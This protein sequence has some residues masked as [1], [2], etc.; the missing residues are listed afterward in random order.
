ME[1]IEL[2]IA[3]GLV[4]KEPTKLVCHGLGSCVAIMVY[5]PK[6]R[7]GGLAHALL[8]DESFSTKKDNS[9][10]F[11]DSATTWLIEE[12]VK[13][14]SNK[15]RLNAKIVGGA[16]LFKELKEAIGN[17]NAKRAEET[18]SR[19]GVKLVV[20]DVGGKRGRTVIF[21]TETGAVRIRKVKSD[22]FKYGWE[23]SMI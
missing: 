23:E 3:Q 11:A 2:L 8:P 13:L 20:K 18:L 12:M 16:S 14:G 1:E 19:E 21:E 4:R 10:K 7:A 5:D 17:E 6:M 22:G 15:R 9:L